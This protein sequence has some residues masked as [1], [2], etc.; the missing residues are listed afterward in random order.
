MSKR[1]GIHDVVKSGSDVKKITEA[2]A[3]GI[4]TLDVED[5]LR[6]L[7]LK[8]RVDTIDWN[9]FGTISIEGG[10][11][12]SGC[13]IT[14]RLAKIEVGYDSLTVGEPTS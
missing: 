12:E 9:T 6:A 7:G 1:K 13:I 5:A 11:N 14:L 8:V 3:M 4:S 2:I 10:E